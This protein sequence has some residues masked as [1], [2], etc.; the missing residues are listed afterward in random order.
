MRCADAKEHGG[1][2]GDFA[3]PGDLRRGALAFYHSAA[4]APQE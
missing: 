2:K 4:E 1:C 3:H